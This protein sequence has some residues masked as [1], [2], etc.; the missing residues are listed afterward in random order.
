MGGG[1]S[2]S[3]SCRIERVN[4][5]PAGPFASGYHARRLV[6]ARLRPVIGRDDDYQDYQG[7]Q[8]W[9][10]ITIPARF[11]PRA[12]GSLRPPRLGSRDHPPHAYL[13]ARPP[14]SQPA[15]AP[16][17]LVACNG[18]I[19][20]PAEVTE[21]QLAPPLHRTSQIET[22]SCQGPSDGDI[23]APVWPALRMHLSTL[24]VPSAFHGAKNIIPSTPPYPGPES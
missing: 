1:S 24:A 7:Y 11:Q 19:H 6:T 2:K 9:G 22:G 3:A 10:K 4:R 23:D 8:D 12:Q 17:R 21:L 16:G 5:G 20:G 14:A 15:C 13:Y 18:L